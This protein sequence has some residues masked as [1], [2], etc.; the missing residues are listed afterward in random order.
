MSQIGELTPKLGK[1]AQQARRR[2]PRPTDGA[3][4]LN[5]MQ[6]G[7]RRRPVLGDGSKGP[8]LVRLGVGVKRHVDG[9][10]VGGL[11][12]RRVSLWKGGERHQ[13]VGLMQVDIG[14]QLV[15]RSRHWHLLA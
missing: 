2:R 6:Q 9:R 5:A 10:E 1:H 7:A 4:R 3:Q 14:E 11:S 12:S 8:C 15:R 13:V